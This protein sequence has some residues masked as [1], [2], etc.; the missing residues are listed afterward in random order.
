MIGAGPVGL[1][2]ACELKRHGASVRLVERKAEPLQ[3]PNAAIVHVRTLE[4]LSA[5]DAVDGFLKEGYAFPGMHVRAFG[6]PIGF[7]DLGGLDSPYPMPR[8]LGQQITE[9]L[10]N[11]HFDAVWAATSSARSRPSAWSR[12]PTACA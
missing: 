1:T 8:T 11:E 2:L 5:M 4:I 7:I 6:K 3:H 12:T 9:R 10:L